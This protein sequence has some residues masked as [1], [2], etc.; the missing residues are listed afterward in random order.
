MKISDIVLCIGLVMIATGCTNIKQDPANLMSEAKGRNVP[1]L[2]Y[3]DSWNDPDF[4]YNTRMAVN[5]LNAGDQP[6]KS[7]T[8]QTVNCGAKGISDSNEPLILNGPFI[9]GKSYT[10][11]PSWTVRYSQWISRKRAEAIA[12]TSSHIVITSIK[13]VYNSEN[14]TIYGKDVSRLLT[15][16]ISNFCRNS[17]F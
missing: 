9:S 8:L 12:K 5:L 15:S 3:G 14:T 6:I 1:L 17:I 13:V 16:N 11:H 4:L 2:I 7:I 10:V